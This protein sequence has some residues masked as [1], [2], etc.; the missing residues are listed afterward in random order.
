M[1]LSKR[2]TW[3]YVTDATVTSCC[4][5]SEPNN[6]LCIIYVNFIWLRK[7]ISALWVKLRHFTWVFRGQIRRCSH[8]GRLQTRPTP[9]P[10]WKIYI[11]I[12]MYICWGP[13][14][15][16]RGY[17][18]RSPTVSLEFFID[19]I[20]PAALWPLGS[21]QPLTEMS[22]RNIS[23]VGKGG[24]WVGLT[25]LPTS[26]ADCLEIWEPQLPGTLRA[27]PGL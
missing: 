24:R 11:Y 6:S 26:C 15:Q 5:I 19:I 27:C 22:T 16:A 17:R 25:S 9:R 2:R 7:D 20:L 12:Y 23:W 14:L 8:G 4:F 18:T 21:T 10:V 13:T 1:K 3:R